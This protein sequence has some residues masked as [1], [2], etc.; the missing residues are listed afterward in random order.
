M[1]R[2]SQL[3]QHAHVDFHD[4][5]RSALRTSPWYVISIAFHVVLILILF[6]MTWSQSVTKKKRIIQ[7]A[8]QPEQVEVLQPPPDP[9]ELK[10]EDIEQEIE[11]PVVSEEDVEQFQEEHDDRAPVDAAFESRDWNDLI[12][13]GGGSGGPKGGPIGNRGG[14]KGGT[15]DQKAVAAGLQ[16]LA[17]HQAPNGSW[18]CDGFADRCQTN[19]CDGP[20]NSLNDV[21]VTG[22]A[23][24]SFLG[25]GN[26][27]G[28]GTYKDVVKDGLTWL[29]SQQ[30]A[31]DGCFGGRTGRHFLYNHALASLAMV[32]GYHLSQQPILKGPAQNGLHFIS[33]ARNPYKA[34]RYDY[35]PSGDNDVSITGWMLF[36]LFA[37]KDAG[38]AVD[39]GA[40]RDGMAYIEEMT[41]P[42]TGRTGYRERGSYPAREGDDSLRWPNELSESMTA[43]AALCRV[44]NHEDP[45]KSQRLQQAEDL[46]IHRLPKWD[47]NAGTIDFY[48]WYYG[49]YAMWQIGGRSWNDWQKA[50]LTSVVENQRHGGDEDGSWDP[51]VD[52][53]GDDGGRVY[54]TAI[55]VLCLQVY[56][57]YDKVFGAR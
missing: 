2:S 51:Q 19:V 44:F 13:T 54:A 6:N 22:L 57:R 46:L 4:E 21:G 40:L 15:A 55:N 33:R 53:W 41:D 9:P 12:G 38:L 27:P 42:G 1:A 11:D 16:W 7:A 29:R 50:M 20:G 56:Y 8:P 31:E 49:S 23:L 3:I 45:K 43:V 26:T 37:G 32:E 36:A 24:L 25:A 28:S 18:D 10:P 30:D 39:D 47:E 48:Y 5:L 52:P 35:P 34:W 14:K 17:N